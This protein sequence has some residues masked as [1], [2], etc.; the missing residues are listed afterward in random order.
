MTISE[1]EHVSLGMLSGDAGGATQALV[2]AGVSLEAV[3]EHLTAVHQDGGNDKIEQRGHC[4]GPVASGALRVMPKLKRVMEN[5]G[6]EAGDGLIA[7]E[8]VFL[9]MLSDPTTL[10]VRI[11]DRLEV[12]PAELR[13]QGRALMD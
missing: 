4:D 13:R 2:A 7:P 3:R 6:M 11:L 1:T 8:H 10:A 12:S 5:A 9:G